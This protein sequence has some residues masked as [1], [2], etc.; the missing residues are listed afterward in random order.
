MTPSHETL[1]IVLDK[2]K[3]NSDLEI[4]WGENNY[5]KLN[6]DKFNLLVSRAKYKNR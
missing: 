2:L 1:E 6:T 4:F 3:E 5:L